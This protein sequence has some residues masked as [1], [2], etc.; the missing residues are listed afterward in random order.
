MSEHYRYI[1]RKQTVLPAKHERHKSYTCKHR[2]WYAEPYHTAH[3]QIRR[4]RKQKQA[5][6]FSQFAA[7]IPYKIIE[8]HAAGKHLTIF[9][10][11]Q[12]GCGGYSAYRCLG[13]NYLHHFGSEQYAQYKAR[14]QGGIQKIFTDAAKKHLED[15]YREHSAITG[16]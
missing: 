5:A 4:P 14:S 6:R 12:R 16:R 1:R 2:T 3:K 7:Y 11:L 9:Q 13:Q 10:K 8:Q 15:Y